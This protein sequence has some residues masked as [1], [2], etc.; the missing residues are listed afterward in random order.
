MAYMVCME[1]GVH[2]TRHRN[3]SKAARAAAAHEKKTKGFAFCSVLCFVLREVAISKL[4]SALF[5]RRRH[6]SSDFVH[7]IAQAV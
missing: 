3:S 4:T 1:G 7:N 2:C 6:C 5:L